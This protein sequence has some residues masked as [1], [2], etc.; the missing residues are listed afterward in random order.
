MPLL[1]TLLGLVVSAALLPTIRKAVLVALVSG[2]V[3]IAAS[4]VVE[5]PTFYRLVTKFSAQMEDFPESP[6]GLLAARALA[7]EEQNPWFGRGFSGFR[8]G[9]ADPRYF[10]GWT[11]PANPNDNGGGLNGCNLHPHN[12]YLQAM[13]DAGLP[14]LALFSALVLAWL[15]ILARGLWR[16][17]DALRV[18]LFVAALVQQWPLASTSSAFAVEIGGLFFLLLGFGLAEAEAA[19]ASGSTRL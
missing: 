15:V 5:P 12:H 10:H 9:C 7:I 14:G 8:T 4:V 11:W 18:G 19:R 6:Y 3:L 2:A 13:T 1:L 17:P 16:R